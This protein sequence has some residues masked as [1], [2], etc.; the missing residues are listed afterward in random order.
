MITINI[1][2]KND[3]VSVDNLSD[4]KG[5]IYNYIDEHPEMSLSDFTVE[6]VE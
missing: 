2:W 1:Y 5:F 3:Y 6:I 4:A